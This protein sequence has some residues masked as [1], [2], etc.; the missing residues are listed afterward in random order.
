MNECSANEAYHPAQTVCLLVSNILFFNNKLMKSIKTKNLPLILNKINL[1]KWVIRLSNW[2][3]R[4]HCL[5]VIRSLSTIYN[6]K[7]S[8]VSGESSHHLPEAHLIVLLALFLC[9]LFWKYFTCSYFESELK[10][11]KKK[12]NVKLYIH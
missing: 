11:V 10:N 6:V 4:Y 8:K 1:S 9:L 2:R 3:I 12:T 7:K 5:R